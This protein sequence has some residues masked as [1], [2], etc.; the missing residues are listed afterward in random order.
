MIKEKD[1][2]NNV[3]NMFLS[4]YKEWIVTKVREAA[5]SA[6]FQLLLQNNNFGKELFNL[7]N[8]LCSLY[9]NPEWH[10]IV[11]ETLDLD[12]IYSNVDKKVKESE[13]EY[14]DLLVK[15][16]LRHFKQDLF[17]WINKPDCKNCN[18]DIEQNQTALGIQ[19]ATAEESLYECVRVE[20]YKC[21]NCGNIT[22]FPRYNNPIKL[23]ET[24]EGRCG[25]FCNV[26]ILILKSFGLETR[27]IWNREDHVWCEYYSSN[28]KRWVHVDP[29]E[30]S[31]D[32]PYIYSINWN[33]EMSYCIAFN[34]EGVT[35][36]SHR[37]ILQNQLPRDQATETDLQYVCNFIT[38][39]LREGMTDNEIYSLEMRD[40]RERLE[41]IKPKI[42]EAT[43]TEPDRTGRASGSADW[44]ST[45]GED[46][47]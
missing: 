38:K 26:F 25:E 29:S 16:L 12:T 18:S 19:P 3:A 4:R 6:R 27:Y 20:V 23:L 36:V 43:P 33:K 40:E 47:N 35:D 5:D 17:K 39:R 37:Y 41:W 13:D 22:R 15:E 30:Q 28:L 44:K 45:R 8:R 11:L 10:S 34:K 21:N 14:T 2:Y 31:F 7:S 24:R 46:G 1:I 42:K 32:Q 9:D